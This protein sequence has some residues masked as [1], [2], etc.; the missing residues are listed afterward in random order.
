MTCLKVRRAGVQHQ[1]T[2]ISPT[3]AMATGLVH[4][5]LLT[6]DPFAT[7]IRFVLLVI[8]AKPVNALPAAIA[9]AAPANDATRPQVNANVKAA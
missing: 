9:A 1:A 7:T 6:T 2:A 8:S 3:A 4:S 5:A